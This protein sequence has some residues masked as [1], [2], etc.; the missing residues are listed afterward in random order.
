M[1][2]R[3]GFVRLHSIRLFAT[4]DSPLWHWQPDCGTLPTV[5]R[6][7]IESTGDAG[8]WFVRQSESRL[9]L[10]LPVA[11]VKAARRLEVDLG[12]SLSP[13]FLNALSY[14]N[15]PDG[16]PQRLAETEASRNRLA[17]RWSGNAP[18]EPAAETVAVLHVLGAGGGG[19]ERFVR[20][21]CETATAGFRHYV[22]R[23]TEASWLLEEA[24]TASYRIVSPGS[25][26]LLES[27]ERLK[28]GVI[29]LH[30]TEPCVASAARRI[31][32]HCNI[33]IG[34][35][36]HDVL[37]LDPTGFSA[38]RWEPPSVLQQRRQPGRPPRGPLC[39]RA[40]GFHCRSGHN[41]L[42]NT[43]GKIPNGIPQLNC[44]LWNESVEVQIGG[45]M[46]RRRIVTLGALGQ[47][48]GGE[49]LF[50][51][52][53]RLPVD[54]VIVVLGYLDG[55]LETGWAKDHHR[56]L[57]GHPGAAR[58]FV[59]GAYAPIDVPTLFEF[60]RP[61]LVYFPG[62]T[63]ESFSY[64]LSETWACGAIPVVPCLG[65]LGE[66]TTSDNAVR[67]Q[68]HEDAGSIADVL[69]EWS[70]DSMLGQRLLLRKN[71]AARLSELIP[72]LQDMAKKFVELYE[73]NSAAGPRRADA[74]ALSDLAE[75]CEI[76]FDPSQ[77]RSELR[78]M[79]EEIKSL[80]AESLE[81]QHW[82][83]RLEANIAEFRSRNNLVE[84][85]LAELGEAHKALARRHDADVQLLQ[86]SRAD[87]DQA[88]HVLEAAYA[89]IGPDRTE[90]PRIGRLVRL[91]RMLPGLLKRQSASVDD[92]RGR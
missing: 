42:W 16:L 4:D 39:H 8:L 54:M 65:A 24:A 19:I 44:S 43:A 67:L 31:A 5:E 66:R 13:D 69:D 77:F 35:T 23:V 25:P 58:I 85:Q 30:T 33:G 3:P 27:L 52:A 38:S 88:G 72:S 61:Q 9:V 11:T 84:Q 64:T 51:V 87:L 6:E 68:Q 59:T 62:R 79:L 70:G 57:S 48:K 80:R 89:A 50:D 29:H 18:S 34:L 49:L 90:W 20:E 2:D 15:A 47:H 86:Q 32:S 40:V 92:V 75:L 56:R 26:G 7:G 36:L 10:D 1:T 91:A 37:F 71:I 76:N 78:T 60:Y 73:Q 46:W 83:E 14:W 28:A 17:L 41:P 81:R 55:Q 53:S 22:V 45:Q 74:K 82:A 12:S 21:L 63:P